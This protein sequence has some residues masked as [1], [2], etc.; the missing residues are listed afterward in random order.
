MTTTG[1]QLIS[2]PLEPQPGS[3]DA[4]GMR[5][6]MLIGI[7]LLVGA[8]LLVN[9]DLASIFLFGAL[10]LWAIFEIVVINRAEPNWRPREKGAIAQDGLF[11]AVSAALLVV[12]DYVRGLIGP[13]PFLV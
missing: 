8:H 3:F 6:P 5:H 12:I 7:L 2:E 9:G 10:G 1:P 4:S 11:L 13:S